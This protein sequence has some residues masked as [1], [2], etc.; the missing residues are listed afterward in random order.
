[1]LQKAGCET[2]RFSRTYSSIICLGHSGSIEPVFGCIQTQERKF[3]LCDNL[4]A[5][6]DISNLHLQAFG[7]HLV[8]NIRQTEKSPYQ[9]QHLL[10]CGL[11][12][13]V[14]KTVSP[15]RDLFS[16]QHYASFIFYQL[17]SHF[18]V[19]FK[20]LIKMLPFNLLAHIFRSSAQCHGEKSIKNKLAT[21]SVL[22][23]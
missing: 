15:D 17:F 19:T 20:S 23:N 11:T 2:Q 5:Y 12:S 16:G 22:A 10:K 14:F 18:T 8:Y 13:N 4:K 21:T 1:M 6:I 3:D 9:L 7:H